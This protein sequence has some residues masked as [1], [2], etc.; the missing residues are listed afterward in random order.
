[1]NIDKKI[2]VTLSGVACFLTTMTAA[3]VS[4]AV[5][6]FSY[7]GTSVLDFND[8]ITVNGV[9]TTDDYNPTTNSYLITDIT[10]T[11]NGSPIDSLL[12]PN[13]LL[14][15]NNLLLANSSRLDEFGFAYTI[16]EQLYNVFYSYQHVEIGYNG[17]FYTGY[18]LNYFSITPVPEPSSILAILSVSALAGGLFRKRFSQSI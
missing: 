4:A 11:R 10:G 1:M 9:L 12:P 16:G 5:F 13:S 17:T 8:T 18:P 6:N 14:D 7:S 2:I 3:P 15:N